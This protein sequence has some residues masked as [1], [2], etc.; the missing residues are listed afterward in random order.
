MPCDR[1]IRNKVDLKL[2]DRNLLERALKN[3][4]ATDIYL[5]SGIFR[6]RGKRYELKDGKLIGAGNLGPVADQVKQ[7]YSREAL[8]AS[9]ERFGWALK[10]QP[11]DNKTP[12]AVARFTL[13]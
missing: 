13:T 8:A 12:N 10:E 9:S 3:M 2:S 5:D 11:L 4:G 7:S 6:Y 1:I